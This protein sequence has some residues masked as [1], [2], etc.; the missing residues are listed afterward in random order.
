M[1]G[2]EIRVPGKWIL[3]GEHSVLRGAPALVFPLSSRFLQLQFIPWDRE[4][5]HLQLSGEH[6]RDMELLFWGVFD[7]ALAKLSEF[8]GLGKVSRNHLRG[9]LKIASDIPIG[10]GLGASAALCVAISRWMQS[11][12]PLPEK[13]LFPFARS[14]ED[15]FHGESSGVDIAVCLEN[16]AL[17]FVRGSPVERLQVRWKPSLYISYSGQRGVTSDCVQKVKSLHE[18]EPEIAKALDTEMGWISRQLQE[19]LMEAPISKMQASL[20]T[21][22]LG[23]LLQKSASIF[24]AWGLFSGLPR[25]KADELLK[26]GALAVK[27]TGS[28]GG[29]FLLSL[30]PEEPS[31][32]RAAQLA[33]QLGTELIPCFSGESPS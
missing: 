19:L 17:L 23:V 25:Q 10:A 14:L 7:R 4:E 31:S 18:R 2:F 32:Q 21:E 16:S 20:A 9:Q 12:F 29:G 13:E 3:S 33:A 26:A 28:G 30:W 27:P 8:P 5:L 15:L 6:G 1:R 11:Q 22:R 24:E